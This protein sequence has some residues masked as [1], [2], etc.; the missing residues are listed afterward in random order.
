[1]TVALQRLQGELEFSVSEVDI[2]RDPALIE[3]YAT[4][5]PVLSGGDVELCDYFLDEQRLRAWCARSG[6]GPDRSA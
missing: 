3:R 4:R 5:V 6:K 2:D 1:M